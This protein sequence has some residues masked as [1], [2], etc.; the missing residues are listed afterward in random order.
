[1]PPGKEF[2]LEL[3]SQ[4]FG[5]LE[6]LGRA[7][8][9]GSQSVGPEKEYQELGSRNDLWLEKRK[10]RKAQNLSVLEPLVWTKTA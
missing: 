7:T 10:F 6:G 9:L 5:R 4:G 2:L 1:M 8:Q 3:G